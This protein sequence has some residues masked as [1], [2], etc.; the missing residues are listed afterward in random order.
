MGIH[1]TMLSSFHSNHKVLAVIHLFP[2]PTIVNII[3]EAD[4]TLSHIVKYVLFKFSCASPLLKH[5]ICYVIFKFSLSNVSRVQIE[6]AQK[7]VLSLLDGLLQDFIAMFTNPRRFQH[8]SI[9][10]HLCSLQ[11]IS[12]FSLIS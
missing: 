10:P 9:G 11:E 6:R 7:H 12:L 1:V 5:N 4:S 8:S 2:Q 3:S